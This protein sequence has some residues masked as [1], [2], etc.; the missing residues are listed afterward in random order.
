METKPPPQA[1]PAQPALPAVP[2]VPE[3]GAKPPPSA[4]DLANDPNLK[5]QGILSRRRTEKKPDEKPDDKKEP[6]KTGD[7]KKLGTQIGKVLG[8][9]EDKPEK[10]PDKKDDKPADEK[11]PDDKPKDD[12]PDAGKKDPEEKPSD[13]TIVKPKKAPAPAIDPIKVATAAGTAVAKEILR[14]QKPAK[15]SEKAPEELLK[16]DDLHEYEVAKYLAESD[17]KF[18]D[19]PRVV[20]EHVKKAE[21][22]ASR[23]EQENKGKVFDPNDEEHD[24]FYAAIE[25]PWADHEFRKAEMEMAAER[26][27]ERKSKGSDQKIQ[28]LEAENARVSLAPV[29]E[30]TYTAAAA[31]LAHK[32]GEEIHD[33]IVKGFDKFSEEDPVTANAMASAIGP[34]QPIIEAAI[35]LDD[36]KMRFKFD[37]KNEAHME[38]NRLLLEKE[39][40]LEGSTDEKGR[41]LVS[42]ADYVAMSPAQRAKHFFLDTGRF[43]EELVNDAAD[44]AKKMIEEEN[45]RLEKFA[46]RAGYV[47]SKESPPP[48]SKPDKKPEDPPKDPVKPASPASAGAAKIDDKV[49]V[50]PSVAKKLLD[51]TAGILFSR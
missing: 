30:R 48:N 16:S 4:A 47:K 25:K 10:E 51:T 15:P 19:A 49:E 26:V 18:K 12:K 21:A 5:M 33:K 9:K 1:D 34:L 35:Q 6:E 20:L 17:P 22:Y 11:K 23:W 37:P 44:S 36:P 43:I 27:A 13:K 32:M 38:W 42:R 45:K 3:G 46:A 7:I 41:I 24:A 39:S 31:V 29:V 40:Q 14:E 50:N 28:E 8:F 2:Q